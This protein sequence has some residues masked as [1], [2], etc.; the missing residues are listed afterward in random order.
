D[1]YYLD[2]LGRLELSG[3]PQIAHSP[4]FC[5]DNYNMLLP[6]IY[7]SNV[8]TRTNFESNSYSF[9][10]SGLRYVSYHGLESDP[11]FSPNDF[12]CC[13]KLGSTTTVDKCCSG[14]GKP[15]GDGTAVT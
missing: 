10:H 13:A 15:F 8:K 3:I 9:V 2:I 14:Y 11:V 5:S 1:F 7:K 12:K 4:L 6:G